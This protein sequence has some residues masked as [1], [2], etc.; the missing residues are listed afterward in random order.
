M[1][2]EFKKYVCLVI[3]ISVRRIKIFFLQFNIIFILFIHKVYM[4]I[5]EKMV[6]MFNEEIWDD[7]KTIFCCI[8]KG[9]LIYYIH[10]MCL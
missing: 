5:Q 10:I 8:Q 7:I 6:K 3:F 4:K 9:L 2:D 1:C